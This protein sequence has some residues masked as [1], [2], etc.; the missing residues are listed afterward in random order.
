MRIGYGYDVHPLEPGR[1]LILGGVDSLDIPI[2]TSSFT[3]SAMR[4]SA[5]WERETWDGII[6]APIRGTRGF[7]A[8]NCS[9]T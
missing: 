3:P 9:R 6:R 4:C 7:Q 1:K 5:P 8:L 2:R